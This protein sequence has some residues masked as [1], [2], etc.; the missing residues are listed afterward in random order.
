MDNEKKQETEKKLTKY[1]RKMQKR[2]EAK[3]REAREENILRIVGI[4]IVLAIVIFAASFPVRRVI[5]KNE[6]MVKVD[7]REISRPEYEYYYNL[8]KNSYESTYG[9][10]LAQYYG[11]DVSKQS[12][13]AMYDEYV[14]FDEFYQEMAVEKLKENA[15]FK[16]AMAEEGFQY[17][18]TEDYNNYI[19]ELNESIKSS[20]LTAA[21]YYHAN[22]GS[23]ASEKSLESYVKDSLAT[24]AF[25][26]AKSDEFKAESASDDDFSEDTIDYE[27]LQKAADYIEEITK[28]IDVEVLSKKITY[29]DKRAQQEADEAAAAANADAATGTA[30]GTEDNT[31]SDTEDNTAN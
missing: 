20:G 31:G 13:T 24:M 18:V 25:Y 6:K 12:G 15:A 26:E 4:V 1:D 9:T 19:A 27:A 3:V 21:D 23:Y 16:K 17:D 30:D 28:D 14:T 7:G 29:D 2:A 11:I 8:S 10:M 5:D 22:F